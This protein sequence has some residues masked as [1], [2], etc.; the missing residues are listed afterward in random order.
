MAK[1][2]KNAIE[3]L[4]TQEGY[5]IKTSSNTEKIAEYTS[6]YKG[7]VDDFHTYKDKV[8]G[9]LQ[10]L[11]RKS[12]QT[13]KMVSEDWASILWSE[14]VKMIHTDEAINTEVHEILKKNNF[15]VMFGHGIE[16]A[17]GQSEHLLYEFQ[18]NTDIWINFINVHNYIVLDHWNGIPTVA[19]AWEEESLV[20]EDEKKK[21]NKVKVMKTSLFKW[22]DGE[23]SVKTRFYRLTDKNRMAT[24]AIN[25]G[26][27]DTAFKEDWSMKST[28][29]HFQV[30]KPNIA[31]NHDFNEL[32]GMAIHANAPD[33][34]KTIDIISTAYEWEYVSGENKVLITAAALDKELDLETGA[35]TAGFD[36]TKRTYVVA[37]G[38]EDSPVNVVQW[39]IRADDFDKGMNRFYAS[40][41]QRCGLGPEFYNFK[42]GK[43]YKNKDEI[44]SS[45]GPLWR[46]KLK[47]EQILLFVLESVWTSIIGL[48]NLKVTKKT[49]LSIKFDDSLITDRDKDEESSMAKVERGFKHLWQHLMEFEPSV[50]GDE[51]KAKAMETELVSKQV[52]QDLSLLNIS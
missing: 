21:T 39:Q 14:A 20:W 4:V 10:K 17:F 24:E 23:T 44:L 7:R 33:D 16:Y 50:G 32:R 5:N 41:G 18:D 43:V 3:Q 25:M 28:R 31:N 8:N 11:T 37:E 48:K 26:N 2:I 35:Y 42:E 13:A 40:V 46:N 52:T 30:I 19:F 49:K 29:P 6:F 27:I 34:I 9:K 47:H 51:T 12:S 38:L 1:I 36:T 22:L 45:K 15:Q